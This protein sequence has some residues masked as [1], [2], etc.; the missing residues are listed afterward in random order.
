MSKLLLDLEKYRNHMAGIIS[1][2]NRSKLEAKEAG[3]DDREKH[4]EGMRAGVQMCREAMDIVFNEKE[5]P[6]N[7]KLFQEEAAIKRQ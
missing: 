6:E 4:F 2:I 5:I 1:E 7:S 3:N